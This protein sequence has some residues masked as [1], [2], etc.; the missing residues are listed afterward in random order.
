M[1]SRTCP[2]AI[3]LMTFNQ[4]VDAGVV[5][6]VAEIFCRV[7]IDSYA[8]HTLQSRSVAVAGLF[9]PARISLI[10]DSVSTV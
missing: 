9:D 6:F 2:V 1:V 3:T 4:F 7:E 8:N 5:S 10:S